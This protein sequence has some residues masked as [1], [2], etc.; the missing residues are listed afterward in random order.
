MPAH[1]P[2]SDVRL[3]VTLGEESPA[4]PA[5]DAP[6][7]IAILG[8][9]SGR[10][11]RGA[12]PATELAR[13]PVLRIDRDD[14]DAALA[15]VAPRVE[16]SLDGAELTFTVDFRELDD[17]HPDR[18]AERLPILR[19]LKELET[20]LRRP[21]APS[22]PAS[23]RPAPPPA[24][25][26]GLLDQIVEASGPAPA[27]APAPTGDA[28][29]D[30]VQ[31]IVA[32]HLVRGPDP[33]HADLRVQADEAAAA[34]VRAILHDPAFQALEALWRGAWLL[35]R[36]TDTDERLR[37][38]LVDVSREE[39]AADLGAATD[40]AASGLAGLLAR[41]AEQD[42][43]GARW[44]VLAGLY[45]FGCD[46]ADLELLGRLG[47]VAARL[48]APWISAAEPALAGLPGFEAAPDASEWTPPANPAW[49]ALRR[50]PEARSIGLA[51]PRFLLRLPY[52]EDTDPCDALE[53]EEMPAG[54]RHD[55]YLWGNPALACALLLARSYARAG[56]A[57]RPGMD[58]ELDD[59]PFH[60]RREGGE[61][62]AQPCAEALMTERVAGRLMDHGLM[63]L[64]SLK[65][66][67]AVRLVRFQS[68]ASPLAALAAGWQAATA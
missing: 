67:D 24:A 26:G 18:L 58:A 17:F 68:I 57:L 50:R 60:L 22:R 61:A 9:F 1:D 4:R 2:R 66:R 46:A 32:P 15:R 5:P 34:I 33:E 3:D 38:Y 54:A 23:P 36:R 37:I 45:T 21:A 42:L 10:G 49:D 56:W 44:A 28:F 63:P 14:L 29:Y 6:F 8:D 55:D 51:L 43:G 41:A 16:V 39:L 40:P 52:G 47:A 19:R 59:L 48:G 53:L 62:T 31:R 30:Y 35:V 64:A 11:R 20:E 27:A 65:D 13:R 25:G 12:A 7:C